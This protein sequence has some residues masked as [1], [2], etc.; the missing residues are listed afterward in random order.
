MANKRTVSA[1]SSDDLCKDSNAR[2]TRVPFKASADK[3]CG[4]YFY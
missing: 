3:L 2:F 1:I 4:A